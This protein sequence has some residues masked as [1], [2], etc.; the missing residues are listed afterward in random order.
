MLLSA[1]PA[2]TCSPRRSHWMTPS[3]IRRGFVSL[4]STE[5]RRKRPGTPPTWVLS[6]SAWAASKVSATRWRTPSEDTGEIGEDEKQEALEQ[7]AAL[8]VLARWVDACE[9]DRAE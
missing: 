1:A 6:I 8:S 9:V 5:P 4:I 3:P 7:L 2:Q